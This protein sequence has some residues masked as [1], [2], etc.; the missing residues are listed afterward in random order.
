MKY[1]AGAELGTRC[2]WAVSRLIHERESWIAFPGPIQRHARCFRQCCLYYN[3]IVPGSFCQGSTVYFHL[4]SSQN[5]WTRQKTVL[6]RAARLP[7][8]LVQNTLVV[9][10]R[11]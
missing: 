1:A 9:P 4:P 10:Q 6:K 5:S 8:E 3:Q 7:P 2:G 11:R